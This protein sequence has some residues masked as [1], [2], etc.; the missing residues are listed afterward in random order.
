MPAR[1]PAV[2]AGEDASVTAGE[3]PALQPAGCQRYSRQD[4]SVT[5]GEDASGTQ[6]ARL[7]FD[8][9][10]APEGDSGAMIAE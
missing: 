4:A 10:K 8:K 7:R 5:T 3:T 6:D 2:Q 9:E 1:T